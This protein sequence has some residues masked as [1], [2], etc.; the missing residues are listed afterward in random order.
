MSYSTFCMNRTAAGHPNIRH[1][2]A[3]G[4]GEPC[5]FLWCTWIAASLTLLAMTIGRVQV[6]GQSAVVGIGYRQ[7]SMN[8]WVAGHQPGRHREAEGRGDP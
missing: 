1:R 5:L 4:R 8:P 7:L 6:D 3:E 2:E